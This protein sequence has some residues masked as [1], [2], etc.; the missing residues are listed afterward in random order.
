M[1]PVLAFLGCGSMNGSILRGVLASGVPVDRVRA[2]VRSA[3]SARPLEEQTGVRPYVTG[4]DPEANRRA[5]R[6]AD[7]VLLGVKPVGVLELA[8]EIAPAL[9]P[10]TVVASVAAGISIAALERALPEGQPVVRT[11]P[12]TPS[13]VR[14]GVVSVT[15]G[16]ATTP[17]QTA[18]VRRV[19]EAV[20]TVVEVPEEHVDAVTGVSGSGPAYVFLLAEALQQAGERMGLPADVARVLARETVSG[21]G[22]LLRPEDADPAALRRAVTSPKGT[23]DRAI[24]TFQE[25]GFED[26]VAAAAQASADRSAELTRELSGD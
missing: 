12:N 14:R 26:L 22:E 6:E 9:R 3:E 18:A 10:G 17:E 11:M 21:A 7:V 8:R 1:T 15:P 23:T 13:S 20:G 5:A 25:N 4:E 2:T 19:L 24:R 16:S